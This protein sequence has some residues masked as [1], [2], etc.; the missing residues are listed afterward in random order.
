M[1]FLLESEFTFKNYILYGGFQTRTILAGLL[2]VN[3][4]LRTIRHRP[5][6][7]TIFHQDNLI[8]CVK[9]VKTDNLTRRAHRH[10]PTIIYPTI[11]GRIYP[12]S[13]TNIYIQLT[14]IPQ[15]LAVYNIK[16][17]QYKC[18]FFKIQIPQSRAQRAHRHP[19]TVIYTPIVGRSYPI[20]IYIFNCQIYPNCWQIS[21]TNM[22]IQLTHIPQLLAVYIQYKCIFF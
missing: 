20:Q 19:S 10:P 18:I 7:W 22:H 9:R 17:I 11:V 14:H 21:N 8:L 16:N 12:T 1:I 15:L 3:L 2:G 4:T 5:C 13:K 6:L